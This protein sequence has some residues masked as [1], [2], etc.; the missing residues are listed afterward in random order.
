M[1]FR[2]KQI[3]EIPGGDPKNIYASVAISATFVFPFYQYEAILFF[4]FFCDC[5]FLLVQAVK[6]IQIPRRVIKRKGNKPQLISLCR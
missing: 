4:C 6:K 3:P 2:G 1:H 5:F